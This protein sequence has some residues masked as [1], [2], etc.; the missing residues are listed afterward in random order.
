MRL[1]KFNVV[2]DGQWG[3][4]GKGLIASALAERYRPPILS[5]T[6]MPNAGHTAVSVN[7]EKFIAKALPSAAILNLWYQD[8]APHVIL[9]A[10]A[11]F[12]LPQLLAEIEDCSL[13]LGL[14]IHPRAGVITQEHR[15]AESGNSIENGSTKHLASTMQGCGAFL[16]QKTLRQPQLKLARDYP[17][18]EPY[19]DAAIKRFYP[20][21][22]SLAVMLN[23]LL[24]A[25]QTTVLHEGAQGFSL[26]VN[27]GSHFPQ[28]T[29]RQTTAAQNV[30]DMGIAPR[31][32]GDVYLV[33]RPYPIRVGN[34]E[35]NGK[36]V[37]YSGDGYEGQDEITWAEVAARCGAPEEVMKGELTT[38]TKRLRRVF[39]FSAQQL[40]ESATI[41]GATQIA[42][43]FAN[44]IDWSCY[45]NNDWNKLPTVVLE[46]IDAIEQISGVPVTIVGCGPQ[47]NHVCF[48]HDR[49]LQTI[50]KADVGELN[51]ELIE[52]ARVTYRDEDP[53]PYHDLERLADEHHNGESLDLK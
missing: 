46:W 24:Q 29:S 43:N 49:E 26:D 52:Q 21:N 23:Q 34:V 48:K 5:A 42:L 22:C 2:T 45:G 37:G 15:E 40:R 13:W 30:A 1:N 31:H 35:E 47:I 7:G 6:S 4:C 28:C 51:G 20:G 36:R 27:H 38:V 14:S 16:A 25:E 9:G 17:E 10:G 33:I 41:N 18:L 19:I 32:V 3:S 8:Y 11:A 12:T 39:E 53:R 44:Y 50:T